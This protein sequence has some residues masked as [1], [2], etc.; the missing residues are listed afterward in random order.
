MKKQFYFLFFFLLAGFMSQA[1]FKKGDILLGGDLSVSTQSVN[2]SN[3]YSD[4]QTSFGISPSVGKFINDNTLIG[5]QAGYYHLNEKQ[6]NSGATIVN[7][8]SNTYSAGVFLRRYKSLGSHF[9]VFLQPRLLALYNRVKNMY[10]D[11]TQPESKSNGYNINLGLAPGIAYSFNDKLMVE[12]SFQNLF[13][14]NYGHSKL[15]EQDSQGAV[16]N[17]F[18]NTGFNIGTGLNN[19]RISNIAVGFKFLFGHKSQGA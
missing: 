6:N 5:I 11:S 16:T 7:N 10:S 9:Y 12:L 17:T 13:Y 1:Q 14:A 19:G 3:P 2:N 15:S 8:S 18:R 4:K